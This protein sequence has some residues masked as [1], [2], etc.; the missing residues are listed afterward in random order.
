MEERMVAQAGASGTPRM[1]RAQA[2]HALGADPAELERR[3]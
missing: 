2:A 3:R 1:D